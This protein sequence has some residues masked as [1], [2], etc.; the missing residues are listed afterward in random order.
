MRFRGSGRIPNPGCL[1]RSPDAC[2]ATHAGR[3]WLAGLWLSA[4]L[5]LAPFLAA[6]STPGLAQITPT[7]VPVSPTIPSDTG[8]TTTVE[9]TPYGGRPLPP[10]SPSSWSRL[11]ESWTELPLPVQAAIAVGIIA[12]FLLGVVDLLRRIALLRFRGWRGP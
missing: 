1:A 6:C 9:P 7:T 10:A 11:I 3:G 12:T 4:I 8:S 2:R 5:V